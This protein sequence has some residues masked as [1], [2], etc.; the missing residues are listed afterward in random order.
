[1]SNTGCRINLKECL[2]YR[3]EYYEA[4]IA[5]IFHRLSL[6]LG[7]QGK[8]KDATEKLLQ[9][10][11]FKEKWASEDSLGVDLTEDDE[12]VIFDQM[13]SCW[14]GRFG[15]RQNVAWQRKRHAVPP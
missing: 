5:R 8:D 2:K 12:A 11:N 15:G 10:R 6:V 7:D 3:D 1:M 4:S 14:A 9:A 13:V